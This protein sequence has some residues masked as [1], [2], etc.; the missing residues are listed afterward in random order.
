MQNKKKNVTKTTAFKYDVG[1]MCILF[2]LSYTCDRYD[3][4]RIIVPNLDKN[5]HASK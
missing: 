4:G 3:N 1:R 5:M 2:M